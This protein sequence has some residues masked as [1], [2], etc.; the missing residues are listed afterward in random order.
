MGINN[1]LIASVFATGI[2]SIAVQIITVREFLTQFSGNEITISL[3]LFCWLMIGGLGSLVSKIFPK[4]SASLYSVIAMLTAIFPLIHITAIRVLRDIAFIHGE[5]PGFYPIF[6]F[7]LTLSAPY[8]FLIGFILP[9]ALAVIRERERQFTA[10][11]LYVTDN[12]GDIAGG[13]L[14]SFVLIYYLSP[15]KIVALSSF[16]LIGISLLLLF[17]LRRYVTLIMT[18]VVAVVFFALAFSK[19]FEWSTLS[20]Q[21][22]PNVETYRESPYGRIVLTRERGE[23]TL[24]ESGNPVF[25]TFN[26]AAAEEKVHYPLC[27]LQRVEDVLLISGGMGETFTEIMKHRPR[28]VDYVELDPALIEVAAQ[29]GLLGSQGDISL[30]PADGREH[31]AHTERRYSAIIVDLPEPDTFQVNR[32]YTK[33]FFEGAKEKMVRG[34]VLSFSLIANPNYLSDVRVKKLSSIF[35]TVKQCFGNVLLIPGEEIYFL[36]R[37]GELTADIPSALKKRNIATTYVEGFYYGNVTGERIKFINESVDS[38]EAI[39]TDFRPRIMNIMFEEWFRKYGTSP[40][41]FMAGLLGVV[42]G[43]LILI[44]REEYVLFSTGFAA[45]GVEMLVLFS[46]QVIYGYVYLKV[47]AIITA[48]LLG[49]L[50]GAILGNRLKKRGK[51]MLIR[52]EIGMIVLLLAYL[53]WATFFQSAMPESVFLLYGFAFSLLCGLQFPVAAEMIGEEQSPAA[54]LFA[55]DL[56]GAGA[57]TLAIGTLLIPLFGIQAA[58]VALI[59]IKTIS[60]LVILKG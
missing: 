45:M 23:Y 3:V 32:F 20:Y 52:A 11:E 44:K 4:R 38:A 39:N 49:L 9:H 57:G 54:G 40:H 25:S 58:V 60:T 26:I 41:W 30:I 7:V 50:P 19:G 48:F 34:G 36:A 47:G 24:W 46:F 59:L 22:G 35:N 56:V 33:E 8:A 13:A 5:S 10:G 28:H 15:F 43:Y 42:I 29:S 51:G 2:S 6:L 31:I 37:D 27:Q 14:C 55:A 18:L 17:R 1:L 53:T 12:M 16:L 21:Y